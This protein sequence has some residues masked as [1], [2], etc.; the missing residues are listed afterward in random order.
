MATEHVFVLMLEN[1]SYDSIFG[2]SAFAGHLPGGGAATANG[3]PAQP[4]VNFGR[5][6]TRYQLGRR[7]PYALGF[8]PG[9]EFTDTCVQLCG[10]PSASADMVRSDSLVLGS[11]GYPPLAVD[12]STTGFAATYEDHADVVADAFS[13]FTP[14]QLPVL[15]FLA[16]Q[17][18]V[19]DSW[20]ASVPGPTW[21]NRFFAV[22]GTSDCFGEDASHAR[23]VLGQVYEY[24]LGLFASAEARRVGS[25]TR[26]P[27]SSRRWS[28]CWRPTTAKSTTPAVAPVECSC[29]LKNSSKPTAAGW[30]T[31]VYGQE[32]NP[33]TWRLA[34]MNLAIRGIDYNP[35]GVMPE[36]GTNFDRKKTH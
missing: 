30:V 25:S 36:L 6:G 7:S 33:T 8:D 19:C 13:A 32:S 11:T 10:L 18:G 29:S 3:L 23:D 26:Q 1:R 34:A 35:T 17:F 15:N 14:D 20:F 2:L 27:P 4:I 9:H 22:A 24:F 31:S 12:P 21:P 5:T 28:R 16:R